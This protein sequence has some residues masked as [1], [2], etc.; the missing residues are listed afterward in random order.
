MDTFPLLMCWAAMHVCS[1][2]KYIAAFV[3]MLPINSNT[4]VSSKLHLLKSPYLKASCEVMIVIVII[5]S[6]TEAQSI[7]RSWIS[8]LHFVAYACHAIRTASFRTDN[9]QLLKQQTCLPNYWLHA[10][11][12]FVLMGCQFVWIVSSAQA[13]FRPA[14]RAPGEKVAWAYLPCWTSSSICSAWRTA[15]RMCTLAG[16]IWLALLNAEMAAL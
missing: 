8:R 2:H 3:S 11:A 10:A 9:L 5:T 1:I 16:S 7:L 4:I 15:D 13:V 6:G 12:S 14:F